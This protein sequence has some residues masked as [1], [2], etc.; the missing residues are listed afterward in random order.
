[1][2]IGDFAVMFYDTGGY[3]GVQPSAAAADAPAFGDVGH[4]WIY[5]DVCNVAPNKLKYNPNDYGY[6]H[7]LL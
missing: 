3:L 2:F 4:Q 1:M 7:L 5:G 6:T